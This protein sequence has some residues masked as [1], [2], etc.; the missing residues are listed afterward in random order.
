M[1][2]FN[3]KEENEGSKHAN[4]EGRIRVRGEEIK[5]E[6]SGRKEMRGKNKSSNIRN[7]GNEEKK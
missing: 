6:I 3:L 5:G 4:S 2:G 1:D 7:K